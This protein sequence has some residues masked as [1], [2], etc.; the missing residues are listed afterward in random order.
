MKINAEST[1]GILTVWSKSR[2]SKLGGCKFSKSTAI[3]IIV[4]IVRT[5]TLYDNN[6]TAKIENSAL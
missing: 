3:I 4:L 5:L 2:P 6:P 1:A